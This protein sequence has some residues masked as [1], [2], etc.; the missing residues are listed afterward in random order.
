MQRLLRLK[1]RPDAVFCYNDPS[2]WGAMRAIAREG[3]R[4]PVDIAV[5]GCGNVLYN[6]FTPIPLTSVDQRAALLGREAATLAQRAIQGR[7]GN[8]P[9]EPVTI[10]LKPTVAVRASTI[11]Y[12]LV[13]DAFESNSKSEAKRTAADAPEASRSVKSSIGSQTS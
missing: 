9:H 7:L 1:A 4:I 6:E 11:G 2:A 8:E 5:A 12:G 10:L 13:R 3:L